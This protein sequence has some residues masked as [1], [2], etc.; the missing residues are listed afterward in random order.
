MTNYTKRAVAHVG[1]V[2]VLSLIAAFFGYLVRVYFAR[3]LTLAE[4]G[5]FYA[6]ISFLGL[7]GIFKGFGVDVSLAYFIP[8][9]LSQSKPQDIKNAVSYAAILLLATNLV[10]L[11]LVLVFST[12]LSVH[13]FK[14]ESALMVLIFMTLSFFIDS[15]VLA[16]KY[17][18][19]GLQRMMVFSSIDIIRMLLIL[20]ITF[21]FFNSGYGLLSAVLA[22]VLTP[23]LLLCIYL[24]LLYAKNHEIFS[25]NKFFWD[26]PLFKSL[27]SYAKHLILLSS[28][29]VLIGYSDRLI[30]TLFRSLEEVGIYSAVFPTAML[31]WYIPD[32]ISKVLLPL[33]SELWSK[34][35]KEELRKG[36]EL[37]YRYSLMIILP[38]S[39]TIFAFSGTILRLF[40]G[41]DYAVGETALKI[42]TIGIIFYSLHKINNNI[43]LGTGNP[44]INTKIL[45][46]GAVTNILLNFLLIPHY[47]FLGSAIA[48]CLSFFLMMVIGFYLLKMQKL[49]D[50]PVLRWFRILFVSAIFLFAVSYLNS[51]ISMNLFL[52]IPFILVVAIL[53]YIVL[54]FVTKLLTLSELKVLVRR[55]M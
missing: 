12:F 29:G 16:L 52:K 10:F 2:L 5:L 9:F 22:Y 30:L 14:H 48:T 42:L 47:G 45:S 44:K 8:R 19:Q 51:M 38:A 11:A 37:L 28:M 4:F 39:F 40:Y 13:Y 31:L 49:V 27:R 7:F 6:V 43:F 32:A 50:L 21:L 55:I 34:G 33:A 26:A 35:L 17:S 36:M 53:V 15:F 3:H 1:I 25:K 54:L 46:I 41:P 23:L 20:G 18:F 24:P